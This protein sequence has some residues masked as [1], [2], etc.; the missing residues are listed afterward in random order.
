MKTLKLSYLWNPFFEETVIY[1]LIKKLSKKKIEI[2]S[3][4]RADLL[5]LGPLNLHTYKWRIF[6]SIKKRINLEKYFKNIDLFSLRLYQPLKIFYCSE[7]FPL[8]SF[9]A[10]YYVSTNLG[11]YEH[12]DKHLRFPHWKEHIDW[13]HEDINKNLNT[14]NAKR[15][16][17][18]HKIEDLMR[19]QG[20]EFLK[21]KNVCI[22][23]TH[24]DG[25]RKSFYFNFEKN[26]KVD[27]YGKYFDKNIKDHNSS[28][29]KKRDIMKN[30]AFNLCPENIMYPGN[31]TEKIPDSFIGKC[32]PISWADNNINSEFNQKAFINLNNF[33]ENNMQDLFDLLKDKNFLTNYTKESLLLKKPTL[34]VETKFFEKI[35]FNL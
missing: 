16:G 31:Y 26:F 14:G 27:G 11:V 28:I 17:C 29:F 32:L 23:A 10:D 8:E 22:F 19:P 30:Y 9:K 13:S 1:H 15:F 18:F 20:D 34:E 4:S 35:I 7:H 33:L 6:N 12:K 25:L 21:K 24:L 5:I 3:P 2:T